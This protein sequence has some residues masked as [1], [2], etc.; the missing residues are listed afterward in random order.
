MDDE[1]GGDRRPCR[2]KNKAWRRK[3]GKIKKKTIQAKIVSNRKVAADHFMME[4]RSPYLGDNSIP[5]QFVTIKVGEKTTDPLLRIPMGVHIIGKKGICLLYKVVGPG[6]EL[7]SSRKKGER[8]NVL[9]PLGNGF[10]LT[11]ITEEKKTEII[12][13]A[14]GHGI[15]PL[16]ALAETVIKK[17]KNKVSVF[18]GADSRKHVLCGKELKQKGAKVH[19]AT[20]DGTRGYEGYVTDLLKGYIGRDKRKQRQEMIYACGPRPMLAALAKVAKTFKIP[21]QVSLDAYMACGIGACLGCT[22]RTVDGYKLVCKDGPVFDA[23]EI[24]W[25]QLL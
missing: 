5:G 1:R 20:D 25:E 21:A 11:P 24:I 10:D 13:V 16:F 14:G 7:L 9:G 8:L 23:R 19:I 12:I 6:T 18:I 17:R 22:V 2:R 3:I 15:A 4:L